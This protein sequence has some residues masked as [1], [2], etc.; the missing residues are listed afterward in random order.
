GGAKA[1]LGGA[2]RGLQDITNKTEKAAVAGKDGKKPASSGMVLRSSVTA[3]GSGPEA[4]GSSAM[5]VDPPA[6]VLEGPEEAAP[7]A[8]PARRAKV[9]PSARAA[10]DI[11]ARDANE[12][13]ALTEYV[14][15]LYDYYRHREVDTRPAPDAVTRQPHVTPRMRAI[16]IDW[17]VEVH[18]KFKLVP[19]T[20]YLTVYIIDKY[21]EFATVSRNNLQL[22]G[23]TALLLASKYEEIFP[24]EVRDLVYI[25]D[26]AYTKE[27]ILE[28][29][30]T[31]LNE[32]NF[33]LTVPT[34]YCFLLR[35]LKAA[36][37]DKRIVQ[38]SCYMAERM[39]QES[40][41][42]DFLPS[43]IASS[44]IY[45]ARKNLN[46]NAWSPTLE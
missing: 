44:A 14:E 5:Q 40:E 12:P 18:L 6:P 11:D 45:V 33:K 4:A 46:R 43:V 7:V 38:L 24:P 2:R 39:L 20:L 15:E 26:R 22:L 17:L 21:L 3:A 32:I 30:T 16:L 36:H 34:V 27:Q 37:A 31:V 9:M 42:L 8:P 19:D 41:M 29:E 1:G 10:T 13:L 28:M 35:Y 23:V 25:T